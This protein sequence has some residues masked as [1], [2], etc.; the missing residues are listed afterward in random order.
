MEALRDGRTSECSAGVLEAL[1]QRKLA[2][3]SRG[4]EDDAFRS[5][6][7][8]SLSQYLQRAR[9]EYC[10]AVNTQCNFNC[11]YCYESEAARASAATLSEDQLDAAF[12]V[13]DESGTAELKP[14]QPEFTLY[15]GEP[16]LVPSKLTVISIMQRVASRGHRAKIITNGYLL[17]E[18]FDVFDAY[19]QAIESIQITLDGAEMDHNQRRVL[20]GGTGTFARIVANIDAFLSRDY[21]TR[22]SIRTSFDGKNVQRVAAL[23]RLLD[24][25]GWSKHPR[26][27]VFPVTIQDHKP[28][29]PMEELIGYD[30]LLEAV[31]PYST[32]S[33][34][35]PFDLSTI[36]VLGHVRSYLGKA[37]KGQE[38]A[39]FS[40]RATFCGGTA[41]RLFVF[42]P[43]NNIYPCYEITGHPQFS[44]GTYYP[45]LRMNRDMTEQWSGARVL[46]QPE[47]FNCTISTFCGGG[48]ASGALAKTGALNHAFCE[49]AQEVFDRYFKLIARVYLQCAGRNDGGSSASG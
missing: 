8:R 15:G 3:S 42:H 26:V 43:D 10:F 47:C 20:K 45:V 40:A 7:E 9:T 12:R 41:L 16:F 21:E 37:A 2:F 34:G 48:C 11:A 23:K 44:L 27:R 39:T 32:D 31:F 4:E 25:R 35:G 46:R 14:P 18:F 29:A 28:C 30:D 24:E 17:A 19:H 6:V 5:L 33:G 36:H 49:G 13:V 38:P 1:A 22:C